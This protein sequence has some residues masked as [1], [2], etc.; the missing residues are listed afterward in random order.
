MSRSKVSPARDAALRVLLAVE[1]DGAYANLELQKNA[2]RWKL[3]PSD[4]A[5]L[6]ELVYGTLRRQGTLDYVI[7][8]FSTVS[9]SRMNDCIRCIMRMGVYQLLFLD[10]VPARAVCNE[11]VEMAKSRR[12]Y[13]LTGFVNALLRK[14][15]REKYRIAYP[16]PEKETALYLSVKH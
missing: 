9:V 1:K 5:F 13:G 10:K 15:S 11:A 12:I 16:D 4:A 7:D 14:I 8:Q 6:T 2:R 3:A